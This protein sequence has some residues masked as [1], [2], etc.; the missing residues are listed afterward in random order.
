MTTSGALKSLWLEQDG[1]LTFLHK[2]LLFYK[3]KGF[4]LIYEGD[5]N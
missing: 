3:M 5:V 4:Y 1:D 2:I